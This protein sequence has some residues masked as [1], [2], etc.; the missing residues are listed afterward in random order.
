MLNNVTDVNTSTNKISHKR[1]KGDLADKGE[2]GPFLQPVLDDVYLRPVETVDVFVCTL[3][4]KKDT[5]VILGKFSNDFPLENLS[6][7]KRVKSSKA[8]DA[9]LQII[10]CL[11]ED[12]DDEA[13]K[14][15][16]IGEE[17]MLSKPY[18]VS[19]P[20]YPPLTRHQ[21]LEAIQYWPVSFHEDKVIANLLSGNYFSKE[22][23]HRF[24]RHMRTAIEY[25]KNAK[26]L[27][28]EPIAAL[29][30]D[31]STDMVIAKSHDDRHGN[32]PL[33]HAV[34]ICID[35]VARSQGGGMWTFGK[36]CD[37]NSVLS[38]Q[39][40]KEENDSSLP[41]LCTGY[42]L[43]VTREPCVMCAMALVH[44]RIQRVFYGSPSK[45]GALGTKF[46]LHVQSGLNHHYQVFKGLFEK[47][48]DKLFENNSNQT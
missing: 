39:S 25:A 19:V 9:P 47:E 21:Y 32:H 46:K 36:D 3:K 8:K 26:V 42:D 14:N 29:I 30:V 1:I 22:E 17:S 23:T 34:M 10:V 31:P 45:D 24:E 13:F 37:F 6:H 5:A 18:H 15:L 35:L 16:G 27:S 20:R 41:Y 48:C 43:F 2:S 44:S 28:K 11:V 40:H 12:A 7:L 4:N 33:H 38:M